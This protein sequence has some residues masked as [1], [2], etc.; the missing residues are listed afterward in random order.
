MYINNLLRKITNLG[1]GN[2][3]LKPGILRLKNYF[4]SNSTHVER[5]GKYIISSILI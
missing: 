5:L 2:Y 3:E 1:E 4:V